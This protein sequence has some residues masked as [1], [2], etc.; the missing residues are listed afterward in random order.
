MHDIIVGRRIPIGGCV[1]GLII[2]GAHVW[3]LT[4]PLTQL[5]LGVV[6]G[7]AVSLTMLAQMLVVNF[8][9]VT[10]VGNDKE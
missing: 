3:N 1:N 9:G 4:H 6:G 2:F 5:D 7:L 8:L 10:H